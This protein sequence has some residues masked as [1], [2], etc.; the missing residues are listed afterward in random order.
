MDGVMMGTRSGS[1]DPS[2]LTFLMRQGDW[3]AMKLD[4]VLNEKS[5]LL[6]VSGVSSDMRS[7][8]AAIGQ[9]HERAKLA[10]DIY[11]HRLRAAIAA[12][13]AALGGIDALVFTA[14]VGENSPAVRAATCKGLEF[15]GIQL[16]SELNAKPTLD[17]DISAADSR[18]RILAIRAEEDWA[19]ATECWKLARTAAPVETRD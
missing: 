11:V 12:M 15:L 3:D 18:V 9:G 14:G 5:G 19:I 8:L 7:I 4:K 2:I 1:V 6:G 17:A 13:A 10:F 16:D